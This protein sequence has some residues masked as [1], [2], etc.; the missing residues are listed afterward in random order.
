[1]GTASQRKW[2]KKIIVQT[3]IIYIF[4]NYRICMEREETVEDKKEL[5][6]YQKEDIDT[7]FEK[8]KKYLRNLKKDILINLKK[9]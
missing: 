6:H 2:R 1:M 8:F 9:S 7:I 3:N 4:G 5:Y